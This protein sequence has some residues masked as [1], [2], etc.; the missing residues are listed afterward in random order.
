[1]SSGF[2]TGRDQKKGGVGLKEGIKTKDIKV[3]FIYFEK[4][5]NAIQ[6]KMHEFMMGIKQTNFTLSAL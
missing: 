1:M 6:Q 4:K 2:H 5:S 3:T